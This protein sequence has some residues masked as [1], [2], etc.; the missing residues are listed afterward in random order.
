MPRLSPAHLFPALAALL[1]PFGAAA[2]VTLETRSAE[3]GSYYKAVFKVGH[4]CD[5]SPVREL[6]VH[7]PEGVVGVKPMPKAGWNLEIQT[8]PLA[9]PYQSHG[10]RIEAAPSS[11]RWSGGN[12]P[13]AFYD[14][15]VLVGRLPEQ[16]GKLYWKVSQICDQGRI[17]WAE[18]PEPGKRPA[19]YTAPA[20]VLDVTAKP[21][22]EAAHK[23]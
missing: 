11:V 5:G 6:I 2:H 4:G 13:D 15:F 17:D 12:L 19:D 8:T 21:G 7:I 10:K 22:G 1:L 20:A 14:E 23:H 16:A 18:I 9:Q 3:A